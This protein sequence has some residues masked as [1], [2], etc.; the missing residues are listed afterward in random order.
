MWLPEERLLFQGDLFYYEEGEPFPPP[1][2][3][4]MKR[5]LSGWLRSRGLSPRV[6][7]GT[8]SSAAAPPEA[9]E[10]SAP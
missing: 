10:L 9:L 1:G 8:H 5:F 7:Y 6:I 3:E 4:T 2:R